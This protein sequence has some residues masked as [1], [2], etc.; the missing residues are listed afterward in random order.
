V[1]SRDEIRKKYLAEKSQFVRAAE[2]AKA[3]RVG[4][5]YV[6]AS[7][8]DSYALISL[9]STLAD[10]GYTRQTRAERVYEI[11]GNTCLRLGL[12]RLKALPMEEQFGALNE[13]FW[14][15][16]LPRKQYQSGARFHRKGYR[17]ATYGMGVGASRYSLDLLDAEKREEAVKWAGRVVKAWKMFFDYHPK[18]YNAWVHYARAQ[19]A[20][21]DKA[22]MERALQEAQR[23]SGKPAEYLEFEE[24]RLLWAV[25]NEGAKLQQRLR[26]R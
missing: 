23:L 22:E 18:Y 14:I 5:R 24:T 7:R 2:Y 1:K 4:F 3:L 20:L 25:H 6:L 19:I 26:Y 8:F 15:N 17:G 13:Y 10:Y 9:G 16:R 12:L 11:L 21:G